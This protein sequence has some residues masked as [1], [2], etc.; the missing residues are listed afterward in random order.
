MSF[1]PDF[2]RCSLI[3]NILL[4]LFGACDYMR[5]WLFRHSPVRHESESWTSQKFPSVLTTLYVVMVDI[6]KFNCLPLADYSH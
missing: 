3:F 6:K 1:L 2:S 5:E 4:T